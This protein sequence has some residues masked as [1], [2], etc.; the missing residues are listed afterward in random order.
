MCVAGEIYRR[1]KAENVCAAVPLNKP[2]QEFNQLYKYLQIYN[3]K[4]FF[5]KLF[6]VLLKWSFQNYN[7]FH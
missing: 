1:M 3:T 6:Q 5:N 7:I 2:S 4:Y